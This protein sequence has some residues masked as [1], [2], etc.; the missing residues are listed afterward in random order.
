M[1]Q[2]ILPPGKGKS[3]FPGTVMWG[4]QK[5]G[6][7]AGDLFPGMEKQSGDGEIRALVRREVG[8]ARALGDR[9]G[10]VTLRCKASPGD[11]AEDTNF[12]ALQQGRCL[13]GHWRRR[14]E[15]G[16]PGTKHNSQT[17]LG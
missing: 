15:K 17:F 4:L 2:K 3:A 8:W 6:R 1:D 5:G 12:G 7:P 10:R 9:D 16:S 13:R 14:R 11:P